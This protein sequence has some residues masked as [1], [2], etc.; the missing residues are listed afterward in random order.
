M[1]PLPEQ[2]EDQMPKREGAA[3][4]LTCPECNGSL[5]ASDDGLT[6]ECRVDH[7]YTF[8]TL[9]AAKAQEVEAAV[10]AAI[11][12]LEERAALLRK[13]AARV[14]SRGMSPAEVVV[15]M[16]EQAVEA[17]EQAETIRRTLLGALPAVGNGGGDGYPAETAMVGGVQP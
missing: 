9:V 2:L 10:W 7:R 15:R 6:Y 3:S 17:E 16:D 5:W 1:Q 14:R 12:A 13:N 4:G 8:D 11:N